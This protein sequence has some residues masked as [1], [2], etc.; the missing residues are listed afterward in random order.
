MSCFYPLQAYKI[1]TEKTE[2]GKNKIVFSRKDLTDRAYMPIKLQ[3]GQCLGCRIEKSRQWAVRCLHEASLYSD[4]CFITLT[5]ST[6]NLPEHGT[7]DKKHFQKFI[8]RLRKKFTGIE[9]VEKNG[10]MTY[11]IRYFHCGEYGEKLQRPHHH[12]CL[13]N[14]DFPDKELWSERDNVRLYRSETLEKLWPFGYSTVGSVTYES[15]AYVARYIFK[16]VNGDRK[17]E[18][19]TRININTGELVQ[20]E[21]EYITMSRRPGIG[22]GWFDKYSSDVYPKDFLTINGRKFK[23]PKYYDKI[24]DEINPEDFNEIKKHRRKLA[25]LKPEEKTADR[26]RC[27]EKVLKAK[28]SRL[29]RSLEQ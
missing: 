1:M 8:K 16:K 21:P 26:L 6:E 18:H 13:F 19:Y 27:K 15:A 29:I 23:P 9:G 20:L 17:E 4:N 28:T 22:K 3:C 25:M 5:Y 12:A 11:P 14:F 2:K 24:Y 10:K 7:L